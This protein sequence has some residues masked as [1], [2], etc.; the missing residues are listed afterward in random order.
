MN[1]RLDSPD[2]YEILWI[3]W[4]KEHI[5]TSTPRV[6]HIPDN[7]A[8]TAQYGER[9]IFHSANIIYLLCFWGSVA[10]RLIVASKTLTEHT[11]NILVYSLTTTYL[12]LY[13]NRCWK[14]RGA[15]S[16]FNLYR[17]GCNPSV[18]LKVTMKWK[19]TFSQVVLFFPHP[20]IILC[21]EICEV[22]SFYI[23]NISLFWKTAA[24]SC[25]TECAKK[26]KPIKQLLFLWTRMLYFWL[27]I[28]YAV[29]TSLLQQERIKLTRRDACS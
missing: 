29:S 10:V 9:C 22:M 19:I 14:S 15:E 5:N 6:T 27:I 24:S 18:D 23:F 13:S 8:C 28:L 7:P 12:L 2:L 25:F 16:L 4:R 11:Q 17:G 3:T 1:Q 20:H 26:K 21:A